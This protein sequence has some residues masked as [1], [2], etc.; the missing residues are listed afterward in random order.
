MYITI[1]NNNFSTSDQLLK[2]QSILD[3]NL[4]DIN[5]QS[6]ITNIGAIVRNLLVKNNNGK[7][8][9]P[10]DLEKKLLPMVDKEVDLQLEKYRE[11][12]PGKPIPSRKWILD[13]Y[14]LNYPGSI[15]VL[16]H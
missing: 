15:D 8:P 5:N 2:V 10:K 7:A 13:H 12:F 1:G 11:H 4:S 16:K 3:R 9:L 6:N 14:V